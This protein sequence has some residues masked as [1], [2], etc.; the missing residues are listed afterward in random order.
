MLLPDVRF[1][2][3]YRARG[4]ADLEDE[5]TL[6]AGDAVRLTAAGELRL[7]FYQPKCWCGRWISTF[8][9]YSLANRGTR[10]ERPI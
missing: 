7:R 6:E 1:V 10:G 5:G 2:H 8:V 3:G 4:R 9:A